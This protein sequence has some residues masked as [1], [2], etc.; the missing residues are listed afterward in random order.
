MVLAFENACQIFAHRHRLC[1]IRPMV[2]F[3]DPQNLP[4][5]FF[6]SSILMVIIERRGQFIVIEQRV[7]MGDSL[8]IQVLAQDEA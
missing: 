5:L 4:Q 3:R 1:I 7:G 2:H 6:S 8:R